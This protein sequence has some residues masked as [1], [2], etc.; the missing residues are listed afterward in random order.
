MFVFIQKD[1]Q[2]FY[3]GVVL[4]YSFFGVDSLFIVNIV[5]DV[6]EYLRHL[7][8]YIQYILR[9]KIEEFQVTGT[10]RKVFPAS[11]FKKLI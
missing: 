5:R 11:I 8:F 1:F 10:V 7:L 2:P 4:L 6:L 3:R 9:K